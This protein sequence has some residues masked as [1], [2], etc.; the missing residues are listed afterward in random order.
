MRHRGRLTWNIM[1]WRFGSDH[2]PFFSWVICRFQSLIFQGALLFGENPYESTRNFNLQPR[3]RSLPFHTGRTAR[4]RWWWEVVDWTNV[5]GKCPGASFSW[6]WSQEWRI[7]KFP[8]R[9]G[10]V[11]ITFGGWWSTRVSPLFL[12]EKMHTGVNPTLFHLFKPQ[13]GNPVS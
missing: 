7:W 13:N 11:Q 4:T 5:F 12:F 10:L 6:F 3:S 1:P 9:I 8:T 2:V